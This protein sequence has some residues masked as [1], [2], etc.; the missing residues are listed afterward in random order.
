MSDT[1]QQN[2]APLSFRCPLPLYRRMEQHAAALHMDISEFIFA[3]LHHALGS[4]EEL[5]QALA[6]LEQSSID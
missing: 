4:P 2:S 5:D 1:E 6:E 3:A